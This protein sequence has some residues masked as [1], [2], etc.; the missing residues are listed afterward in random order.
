MKQSKEKPKLLK[1]TKPLFWVEEEILTI[2]QVSQMLQLTKRT[3]YG[4][5]KDGSIPATRI[6]NKFRFS[7]N[8][9]LEAFERMG[10]LQAKEGKKK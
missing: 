7:K 10:Q 8:A 1:R 3:V 5:V 2:D 9:V 4:L 6:G